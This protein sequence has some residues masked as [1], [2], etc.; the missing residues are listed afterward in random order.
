MRKEEF[1]DSGEGASSC[2]RGGGGMRAVGILVPLN[3]AF[4]S[5]R[6][7]GRPPQRS[8]VNNDSHNIMIQSD[9]NGTKI[10]YP[11]E[12]MLPETVARE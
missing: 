6:G 12:E 10:V 11:K 7:Q 1:A 2:S 8:F 3:C 5:Y 4:S 9:I